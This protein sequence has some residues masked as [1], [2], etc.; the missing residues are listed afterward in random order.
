MNSTKYKRFHQKEY[1]GSEKNY[2]TAH[3]K[4]KHGGNREIACSQCAYITTNTS[5][6]SKHTK[7]KH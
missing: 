2:L 1:Q 3:M 5:N 7:E 4:R 6:S